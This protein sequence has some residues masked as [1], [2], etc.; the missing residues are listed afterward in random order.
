[1]NKGERAISPN[2]FAYL[3]LFSWPLVTVFLYQRLSIVRATLWTILGGMLLL[4]VGTSVDLPLIPPLNKASIP[5]LAAFLVCQFIVGK[6]IKL[7]PNLGLVKG[8]LFIYI[9][10]PFV[11][12]LLNSDAIIAGPLFI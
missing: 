11:T 3:A 8:L 2:W 4:P 9:L 12:A 7:L 5:N 6:K 10:S 1:M